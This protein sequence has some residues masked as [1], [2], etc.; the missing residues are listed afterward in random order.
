MTTTANLGHWAL[1]LELDSLTR[2]L[3]PG[4]SLDGLLLAAASAHDPNPDLQEQVIR[5]LLGRGANA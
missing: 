3:K 2:A 1:T 5:L 4:I